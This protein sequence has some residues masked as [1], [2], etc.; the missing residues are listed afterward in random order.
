MTKFLET[1]SFIGWDAIIPIANIKAI[2]TSYSE[3]SYKIRIL[4]IH[5]DD[6]IECFQEEDKM[7]VRYNEIKKIIGTR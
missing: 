5:D 2:Y 4:T 7:H 6:Y 3:G 1:I